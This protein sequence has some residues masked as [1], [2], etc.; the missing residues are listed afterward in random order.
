MLT[1]L[2][3]PVED[4][5]WQALDPSQR[6]QQL[7]DAIKR[8]LI[9]ESQI[10]PILLVAENL[11]W[12]DGE[13]QALLDSLVEGLPTARLLLLVTYRPEYHHGWTSK[14]YYTQLRLDPLPLGPAQELL[15]TLLGDDLSL[16]PL[17]QSLLQRTEGNP[18]FLEESVQTLVETHVLVGTRGAY[19]LAKPLQ[20]VQV[21]ATVQA[22][23]VARID[24]LPPQEKRLL[25]TAAV[26]GMEVP[27][28]LVQTVVEL[29]EAEL[30]HGLAHLQAT[31]F[32]YEASLFPDLA[33]TFKHALTH[34]VAYGSL[35]LERRRAL[36][37]RI[38][39]ALEALDAD[40]L[41]EQVERLPTMPCGARC[42]TKL[43]FTT[44]RLAPRRRRTRP[45]ARRWPAS[46]KHW[47]L[48]SISL[49]VVT[50]S[51]RPSI[52]GSTCAMRFSLADHERII[53]HLRQAETLAQ[54]LGDQR[55][56]GWVFSYMTRH[57][58]SKRTMAS[59]SA[60]ASVPLPSLRPSGISASKSRRIASWA[61]PTTSGGT[62]AGLW[63][64]S[65]GT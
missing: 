15:N 37:A 28:A 1:L 43:Y 8:L 13:T 33:F 47:V 61:K 12:I 53:E 6:R 57:F 45:T 11:H 20:N 29:P 2:D 27:C 48:C 26:I 62:I 36:H 3:V 40:R 5:A 17:M 58:C 21:P 32:L 19:R 4:A 14:T 42:G 35:L 25:Q 52:C 65:E 38:V 46:S 16:V 10:Q 30:H 22:M 34:E 9:R 63:T 49:K 18:F 60:Q 23:L 51:S 31:E 7:L 50:L 54:A 56:L 24:R 55:R 39:E 59:P 41:G 64:S 44:G